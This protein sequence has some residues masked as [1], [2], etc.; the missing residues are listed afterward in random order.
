[1]KTNYK[2]ALV[3]I[4]ML[5][6]LGLTA[7]NRKLD[8]F[9]QPD[10]NGLNV[11]ESPKDTVSTFNGVKV[12]IGGSSTIQFQALDHENA[13]PTT[14]NPDNGANEQLFTLKE[15]G[16]NFNL[17]TANLDIDVV[18]YDGVRMHLRTYLSSRH[19]TEP[20][21]KGGYFQID[22]LEFVGEGFMEDFMKYA[23]I[24]I[25]HMENNYGDAHFRRTD[26]AQAIYNPFV[27]NLIMDSFTTEVGAEL[28]YQRN[29]FIG[30]V[31]LTNGKLNQSV[32]KKGNNTGGASFLAK[33]GY[34]KQINSDFR[35]RLTGSMYNT[36]SV[37]SSYLYSA[38]RTGSRYYG[39]MILDGADDNFRSGRYNPN[40]KNQ[41]TAVMFNPFLKYK[42]LEFFGTIEN[43][44]GKAT[45]E[46]EK[47]TAKQYAGELIYRFGNTENL[48]VGTRYN[49]LDSEES[50]GSNVKISRFQV[51]GGWFMTENI[52]LKAE[53]VNQK[54]DG[55]SNESAFGK[56]KFNGFIA[57]A[58]ISF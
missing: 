55:Y 28:Y 5:V 31:G 13:N 44:T 6:T 36:G 22:K 51:S 34:D 33:L 23:T 1:M 39:V 48:Y 2:N 47:R 12:R 25:G 9:R 53:Y 10:K 42:N 26:N 7:Q 46:A 35:F 8:N 3:A 38:D 43:A 24:K 57:E 50:N 45:S 19:H 30:M 20:Y 21:V 15:I 56:G 52:L 32:N 17:A 37:Q 14:V 29:G 40:L 16:S 41:I 4:L 49:K 27:G 54:Y 18:L 58:V 11:F